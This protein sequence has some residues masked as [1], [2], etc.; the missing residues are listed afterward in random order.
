MEALGRPT[1][2]HVNW[3]E[4]V[5]YS[6]FLFL[7][8]CAKLLQKLIKGLN[9][10]NRFRFFVILLANYATSLFSLKLPIW[11]LRWPQEWFLIFFFKT[12][13]FIRFS[14]NCEYFF[15]TKIFL[16]PFYIYFDG[17]GFKWIL[18]LNFAHSGR[19]NFL[20]FRPTH[21]GILRV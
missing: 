7:Y 11:G 19:A 9:G 13:F 15:R 20:N 18:I 6:D 16:R 4:D 1:D 14:F 10:E 5:Y 12:N 21:R 2:R 17:T 8:Y 3:H